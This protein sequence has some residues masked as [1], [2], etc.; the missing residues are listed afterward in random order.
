MGEKNAIKRALFFDL[1]EN[2]EL[3]ENEKFQKKKKSSFT[4]KQKDQFLDLYIKEV[5]MT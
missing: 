1:G 5:K 4:P 2:T 3:P